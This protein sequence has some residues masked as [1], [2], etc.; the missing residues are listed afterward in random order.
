VPDRY[1]VVA[2][3]GG[4]GNQLFQY[5]A[6]LGIAAGTGAR[7]TFD[8]SGVD[9]REHWL[10]AL[11]GDDYREA[12]RAELLRVGVAHSASPTFD[13]V[14]RRL[15]GPALDAGRRVRGRTARVVRPAALVDVAVYD[16]AVLAVDLP[17]YLDGWF[18]TER[19]FTHVADH[20]AARLLGRLPE[21][22]RPGLRAA[23]PTVAVSFRRGDY[24]RWGWQLPLGYYEHAL[25]LVAER[26]PGAQFVLL[27]DDPE[28]LAFAIPWVAR[29]GP[30][31]SA[32]DSGADELG[33]LALAAACDHAVIANSSFAWWGA[34]LGDHAPGRAPDRLVV[35]PA[36]YPARFGADVLASGWLSVG[37]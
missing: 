34:W 37:S 10:P 14:T 26:V 20:I 24:V 7:L 6:G 8:P 35:A 23:G 32:Y 18:Q 2:L 25:A 11:V 31:V 1:L 33:H 3:Q 27:G 15:L 36:D 17:V 9:D 13:A 21:A 29:F 5:A 28:F 22:S 30:A 19:W 4:L 12:T 16:E